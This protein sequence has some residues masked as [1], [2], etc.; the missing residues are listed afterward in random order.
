[1]IDVKD[2]QKK[3]ETIEAVKKINFNIKK[4]QTL[5]LL[6]PNGC[7]KTTTIGMLLGLLKPTSGQ[8]FIN[9]LKL[10]E[11]DVRLLKGEFGVA[12]KDAMTIVCACA[13]L[14]GAEKLIDVSSVHI[15]S[16]IFIG[17]AGMKKDQQF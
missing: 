8:I 16:T 9:N 11:K 6:G 7:G 17:E 4:N 10:E 13:R 2:L 12:A 1:M 14:Q 15:D 3:F 5:A